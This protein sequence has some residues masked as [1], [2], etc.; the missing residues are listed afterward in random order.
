MRYC[1]L[2]DDLHVWAI[3][4]NFPKLAKVCDAIDSS[5]FNSPPDWLVP[6]YHVVMLALMFGGVWVLVNLIWAI[7]R[8]V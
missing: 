5:A 2:F 4:H 7:Q 8:M 1:G 6:V 3:T